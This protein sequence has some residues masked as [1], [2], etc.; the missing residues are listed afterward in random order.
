MSKTRE[1]RTWAGMIYRCTNPKNKSWSYY[2][3]RGISVC[4]KW[5]DS[6]DEFYKDMGNKPKGLSI[7]RINNDGNYEPGNCRWAT[8]KEQVDNQRKRQGVSNG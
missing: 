1:Y 4:D 7:D 5:A 6:F 2:G 3:G 8:R